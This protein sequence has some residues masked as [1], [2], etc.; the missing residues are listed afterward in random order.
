MHISTQPI[1]PIAMSRHSAWHVDVVTDFREFLA[2]EPAWKRLAERAISRHPF[3]AFDWVRSWW[4]AFGGGRE[5]H[6]FVASRQGSREIDAIA[7]LML[8]RGRLFGFP[9][10][11]LQSISNEQTPRFDFLVAE[12]AEGSFAALWDAMRRDVTWDVLQLTQVTEHGATLAE[13]ERMAIDAELPIGR[14]RSD[15]SPYLVFDGRDADPYQRAV[16]RKHRRN[17]E[18]LLRRLSEAGPVELEIFTDPGDVER[19]L[20]DAFRL[21]ASGW[22]DRVGT[23]ILMQPAV[24]TFYR[25]LARR[26]GE[27]RQLRLIFLKSNGVRIAFMYG[28]RQGNALFL[29]KCGYDP[30]FARYAPVHLLCHLLFSEARARALDTV[31]FLGTNDAWKQRWTRR[32][33]QHVWL[34]VFRNV[35]WTRWLCRT[36]FEWVPRLKQKP[37]YRALLAKIR[38]RALAPSQPFQPSENLT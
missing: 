11:R 4:E 21:E 5:L 19:A 36:K 30:D 9:I 8:T 34:F 28:V 17:V 26:H 15:D 13:V 37:L 38:G 33:T 32:S 27:S 24:E 29:V 31:E 3:C 10:R 2:L 1:A 20:P 25:T 6:V 12:G 16:G 35:W 14:W 23:S 7:P 22:K 18:R